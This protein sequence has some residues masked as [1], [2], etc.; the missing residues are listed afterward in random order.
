MQ[1]Y[2]TIMTVILM[3]WISID[4]MYSVPKIILEGNHGDPTQTEP[5]HIANIIW[6]KLVV[7]LES[8][9]MPFT[10]GTWKQT[11]PIKLD[12]IYIFVMQHFG[13]QNLDF[14][15]LFKTE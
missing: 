9:A 14:V 7:D 13:Y 3:L 4:T 6:L 1:W 12:C 15:W 10:I 5:V 2:A 8:L 11:M